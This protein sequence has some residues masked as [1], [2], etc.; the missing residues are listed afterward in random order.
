M[1]KAIE[2]Y[3]KVYPGG[4]DDVFQISWLPFYLDPTSPEK[5]IPLIDR[6]HQR[7]GT[8]TTVTT[9]TA[10]T[11]EA[12]AL[13]DKV[14]ARQEKLRTIGRQEGIT[15]SFAGRI[16]RTRDSHRLIDLAGR[17][18]R[19]KEQQEEE[20]EE[21][22]EEGENVQDAVVLALFKSY[23]EGEGDITSL[24]TLVEAGVQGGLDRNEVREWL[25][26]DQGGEDV[27]REVEKAR[28]RGIRGVPNFMVQG[29]Y[30]VD[31]AQDPH[32]FLEMFIKVKEMEAE[33]A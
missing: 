25:E 32:D 2:I 30:E 8:T 21:G 16:G 20:E 1:D 18:Q 9:T 17:R 15:F 26:T 22:K 7:Y 6:M 24:D 19:G 12:A 33:V 13:D 10:T 5:G 4:K 11:D 14:A 23:F 29:K 31:G 3:R 28:Q 27:D